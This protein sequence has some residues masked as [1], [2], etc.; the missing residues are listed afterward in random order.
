MISQRCA[1]NDINYSFCQVFII[2]PG[3][4]AYD[5]KNNSNGAQPLQQAA[6]LLRVDKEPLL[7]RLNIY[8]MTSVCVLSAPSSFH[9]LV[10]KNKLS[11]HITHRLI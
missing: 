9:C 10:R 11:A 3:V 4:T 2:L 8:K 1:V 5:R 6:L 7:G